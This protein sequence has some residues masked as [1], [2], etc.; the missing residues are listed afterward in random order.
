MLGSQIY[1]TILYGQFVDMENYGFSSLSQV[2]QLPFAGTCN[3]DYREGL[4]TG[5]VGYDCTLEIWWNGVLMATKPKATVMGNLQR[6]IVKGVQGPNVLLLKEVGAADY[7]GSVI[8]NFSL[9]CV[10][11]N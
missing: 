9:V 8:D 1:T 4:Y 7:A 3:L 5:W 2:I 6:T 10:F 11:D